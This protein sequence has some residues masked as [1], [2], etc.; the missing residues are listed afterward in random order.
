MLSYI[1]SGKFRTPKGVGNP[2]HHTVCLL[3]VTSQREFINFLINY[4]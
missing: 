2:L 1:H 3:N 4:F